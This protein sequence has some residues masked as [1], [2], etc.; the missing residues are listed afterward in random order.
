MSALRERGL[1][2]AIDGKNQRRVCGGIDRSV[3]SSGLLHF[4]QILAHDYFARVVLAHV[5]GPEF[6]PVKCR[7]TRGNE[8]R[9]NEL[10]HL[11]RRGDLPHLLDRRV[12]FDDVTL[13][14]CIAGIDRLHKRVHGLG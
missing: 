13:Q 1:Q 11:R 7:Q 14:G 3:R 9:E 2:L 4:Q 10:L 5:G 12:R 6:R 8:M